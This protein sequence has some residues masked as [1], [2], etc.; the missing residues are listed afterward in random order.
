MRA[1]KPIGFITIFC[2]LWAFAWMPYAQSQ[3]AIKLSAYQESQT[4]VTSKRLSLLQP[5]PAS[6]GSM[7]QSAQPKRMPRMVGLL[8]F[9]TGLFYNGYWK[10][11]AFYA[12]GQSVSLSYFIMKREEARRMD[13][14]YRQAVDEFNVSRAERVDEPGASKQYEATIQSRKDALKEQ[15]DLAAYGLYAFTGLYTFGVVHAF[16]ADYLKQ[17]NEES[18]VYYPAYAPGRGWSFRVAKTF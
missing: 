14:Q 16:V 6:L 7:E 2:L 17:Q 1:I 8:P 15:R 3:S 11:G 9:G 13:A 10:S 5:E 4:I 12:L 18:L